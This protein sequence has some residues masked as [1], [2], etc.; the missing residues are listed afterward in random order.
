MRNVHHA[1]RLEAQMLRLTSAAVAGVFVLAV[2]NWTG[3][4]TG[5]SR[6][7]R[8]LADWPVMTPWTAALVAAVGLAILLQSGRPP[9]TRVR[10]GRGVALAAGALAVVFLLE[11]VTGRSFGLDLLWFP[12]SV[13]TLHG[14]WPGR[15]S[16]QTSWAV[17]LLS[18]AVGL[19]REDRRWALAAR[20]VGLTGAFALGSVAVGGYLFGALSLVSSTP[21]TG[22]GI[23]T[24]LCVIVLSLAAAGA[25]PDR[26]PIA[27]LLARPD[28]TALVQLAG[29]S[30]GTPVLVALLSWMVSF[31]GMRREAAWVIS[32]LIAVMCTG[33][34]VFFIF[35]RERRRRVEGEARLQAIIANAPNSIAIR[36]PRGGFEYVNQRFCD[37]FGLTESEIVGRTP[38]D[39]VLPDAELANDIAT[40]E[41]AVMSGETAK[42][43]QDFPGGVT[44]EW[45]LFPV[46]DGRGRTFGFGGI[47]TDV[48]ERV[49]QAEALKQANADARAATECAEAANKAKSEFLATMSHELRTPLNSIMGFSDLLR[50]DP[51][52]TADQGDDLDI[53]NRSGTHL[54]GLINQVLD[55]AKIEAGRTVLEPL[56]V[57]LPALIDD[58]DL[59]MRARAEAAGLQLLVEV[60]DGSAGFIVCDAQKVRQIILNLLGNALKFTTEGGVSLRVK[61]VSDSG[62]D[63]RVRLVIE[64]EDSGAGI[65]EEQQKRIFEPFVQLQEVAA[66][67]TGLGLSIVREYVRLM[68]GSVELSSRVG[69]G[70]LFRVEIPVE[71]ARAQDI[72][73]ADESRHVVGLAPGQPQW[74]VLVVEDEQLNRLL[75]GRLLEEAGFEVAFAENGAECLRVFPEFRPHF[76]WMDRRMPVMDGLEATH[77]IREREDG[78]EVKIAAITASVFEDQREEWMRAGIDGFIR[79]PF[80]ESEI[81]DCMADL[82]GVE[83]LYRDQAEP[84]HA[85]TS[86]NLSAALSDLPAALRTQLADALVVGS[87]TRLAA[88]LAEV[89]DVSPGLADLLGRYLEDFNYAPVLEALETGA[90]E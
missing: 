85:Q 60:T 43:E 90:S 45:Q 64:V 77:R 57:N 8:F 89:R 59:M 69:S 51:T 33:L 63:S 52:M 27:W 44:L 84:T 24:A 82:L 9:R 40:A 28:R 16:P 26:K 48:T 39:L 66:P 29:V 88:A 50:R 53:I 18:V 71:E 54:L 76:I 65:P 56:P 37:L 46:R 7:T 10:I 15:P 20:A 25:R 19:A 55:M 11:Y 1:S 74:R 2:V 83:Y 73:V 12:D 35:E 42:F 75:L 78:A 68:G 81:F 22:M 36:D 4:A 86:P 3:W 80:R 17:V 23:S 47:G 61:T 5:R 67:G 62:S 30:V 72:S 79:K 58:V 34:T 31:S 38:R 14:T 87:T 32:L 41:A 49:R 13:R 21:S 6:L 70:S